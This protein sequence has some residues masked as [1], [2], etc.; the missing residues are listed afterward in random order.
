M[1]YAKKMCLDS[2]VRK[3]LSESESESFCA[4]GNFH[5]MIQNEIHA[6]LRTGL[7]DQLAIFSLAGLVSA[8]PE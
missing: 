7:A 1:Q 5:A 8:T 3:V 6:N 4:Y 2:P